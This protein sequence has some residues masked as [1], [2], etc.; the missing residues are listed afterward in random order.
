[1][2]AKLINTASDS[3]IDLYT[4]CAKK[5]VKILCSLANE[6]ILYIYVCMTCIVHTDCLLLFH[7]FRFSQHMSVFHEGQ[8]GDHHL[9][10]AGGGG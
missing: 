9:P 1:M 8:P 5:Y 6:S 3:T 7:F 4:E 10:V 2:L